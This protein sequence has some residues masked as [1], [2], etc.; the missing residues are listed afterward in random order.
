M[1]K[2]SYLLIIL[3]FTAA[4]SAFAQKMQELRVGSVISGYLAD[5]Q[6]VLYYVTAI[7]NGL[8]T[9]YTEGS[10]DTYLDV[11]DE[12][13]NY[14]GSDDDSGDDYNA[15]ININSMAG[16]TFL[17]VLSGY[18]AGPYRI[19]ASM[20]EFPELAIGLSHKDEI[21]ADQYFYFCVKP[22]RSGMLIVE[23]SGYT[24]TVL[25]IYDGNFDFL[26]EDDDGAGFPND[27]L[28]IQVTSGKTYYIEVS[29]YD[30]GPF[31]VIARIE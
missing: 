6:E 13:D 8:L 5:E 17:I 1:R 21:E 12:D 30:S 22:V 10:T 14:L 7:Q 25:A 16:R 3:M 28:M 29:A 20:R 24:D 15:V 2:I 18:D 27:R 19:G 23:T 11:Y 4:G 9:I 26:D 31:G